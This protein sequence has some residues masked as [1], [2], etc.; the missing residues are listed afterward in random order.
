MTERRVPAPPEQGS[1]PELSA[2]CRTGS[3]SASG[4]RS[5]CRATLDDATLAELEE[6]LIAADLGV[7]TTATLVEPAARP[8]AGA[9]DV[10]DAPAGCASCWPR[11]SS[12]C[13]SRTRRRAPADAGARA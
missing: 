3:P 10:G 6:A 11:R 1:A 7:E 12:G 2:D 13:C 8:G 4:R 5:T 9:A